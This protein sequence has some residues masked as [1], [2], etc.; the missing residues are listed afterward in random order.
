MRVT[1][2]FTTVSQMAKSK[3]KTK[4]KKSAGPLSISISGDDIDINARFGDAQFGA[5]LTHMVQRIRAGLDATA[6]EDDGTVLRQLLSQLSSTLRRD[7]LEALMKLL[8]TE[9]KILLVEIMKLAT[10]PP[11]D[12]APGGTQKSAEHDFDGVHRR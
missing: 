11:G 5:L 3:T 9:Q 12:T 6:K 8:D 10:S 4:T 1:R 7:Q 2:R